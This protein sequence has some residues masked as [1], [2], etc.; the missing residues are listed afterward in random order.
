MSSTLQVSSA[1]VSAIVVATQADPAEAFIFNIEADDIALL[2][3]TVVIGTIGLLLMWACRWMKKKRAS[4]WGDADLAA[5]ILAEQCLNLRDEIRV[6]QDR[7]KDLEDELAEARNELRE[8]RI[9]F[10][11]V[12][13]RANPED[14]GRSPQTQ[15]RRADTSSA[16]ASPP[17]PT[18]RPLQTSHLTEYKEL[19]V[20][21]TGRKLHKA[22]CRDSASSG[23]LVGLCQ[24]CCRGERLHVGIDNEA[25]H[26]IH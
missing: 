25:K 22:G 8:A 2:L 15:P 20:T 12:Y 10:D 9:G 17:A 21:E 7:I 26:C 14:T 23:R 18:R 1:I 4:P 19:I 16:P 3:W 5:G 13:G 24:N 6:N 11:G